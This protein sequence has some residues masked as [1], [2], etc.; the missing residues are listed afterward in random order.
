M[1]CPTAGRGARLE[2]ISAAYRARRDAFDASLQ[3]YFRDLAR[4]AVP[5]GGLFFWLQLERPIDTRQL[6]AT[7]LAQG[8]AFMPGEP[9]YPGPDVPRGT[10]RLN[11]S[12]ADEGRARTGLQKLAQIIRTS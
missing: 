3:E 2:G 1:R 5:A 10:L 12:H 8:V 11:F 9:F 6:L 7:A 4:W